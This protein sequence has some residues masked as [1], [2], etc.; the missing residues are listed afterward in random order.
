MLRVTFPVWWLLQ[1]TNFLSDHLVC[2]IYSKACGV[3]KYE[4]VNTTYAPKQM[5]N[6][7]SSS[8]FEE[9]KGTLAH[10]RASQQS[11]QVFF[12]FLGN[13]GIYLKVVL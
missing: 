8:A 2:D 7:F 13:T 9:A 1:T 11:F 6:V 4:C 3:C 10:L 5:L 12:S